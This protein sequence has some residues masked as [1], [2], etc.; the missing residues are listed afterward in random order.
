VKPDVLN[1]ILD[2]LPPIPARSA[3]FLPVVIALLDLL[4]RETHERRREFVME[5]ARALIEN[6]HRRAH[7]GATSGEQRKS[8]NAFENLARIAR[9]TKRPVPRKSKLDG[10]DLLAEYRDL[11]AIMRTRPSAGVKTRREEWFLVN[12]GYAFFL[13]HLGEQKMRRLKAEVFALSPSAAAHAVLAARYSVKAE[14][15]K[16]RLQ[17]RRRT[18]RNAP[19]LS[20]LLRYKAVRG[21]VAR[22]T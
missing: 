15:I 13:G 4:N 11:L 10:A 17:A 7:E 8:I 22:K 19:A 9:R 21:G 6:Y 12:F 20:N 5:E 16:E 14:W 3:A 2:G 18:A 1:F